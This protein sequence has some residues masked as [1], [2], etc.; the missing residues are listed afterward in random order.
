VIRQSKP[1]RQTAPGARQRRSAVRYS[2][3][4]A[5]GLTTC[6]G[7]PEL[8]SHTLDGSSRLPITAAMSASYHTIEAAR[9]ANAKRY[10]A[11]TAEH[12]TLEGSTL[13]PFP[14]PPS[15]PP[16]ALP[17]SLPSLSSLDAAVATYDITYTPPAQRKRSSFAPTPVATPFTPPSPPST[18]P[19]TP[20]GRA[21]AP[22]TGGARRAASS[23]ARST[24]LASGSTATGLRSSPSASASPSSAARASTSPTMRE[25]QCMDRVP[26]FL[27]AS[28]DPSP[29]IS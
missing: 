28:G 7:V 2:S 21:A 20:S 24:R 14:L 26:G 17:P 23:R 6:P 25:R 15:E 13:L 10:T 4:S 29:S 1:P 19:P 8:A 27:G 9:Q 5:A 3:I 18:P 22:S 11:M 12:H 16:S